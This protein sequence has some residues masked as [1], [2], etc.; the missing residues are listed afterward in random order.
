MRRT[1]ES[2]KLEPRWLYVSV[3]ALLLTVIVL[4]GA[5]LFIL[6][7]FAHMANDAMAGF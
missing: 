4:G 2:A 6:A 1:E 7:L 3:G 5:L